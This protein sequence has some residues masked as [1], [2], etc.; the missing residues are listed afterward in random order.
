M[1][2]EGADAVSCRAIA[3]KIGIKSALA[4]YHKLTKADL[5]SGVTYHCA[6]EYVKDRSLGQLL[7]GREQPAQLDMSMCRSAG[8]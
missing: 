3:T 1:R 2:K 4:H 5:F 8:W 6:V 7:C